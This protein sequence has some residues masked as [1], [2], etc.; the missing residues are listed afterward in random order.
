MS[1]IHQ[2]LT[3]YHGCDYVSAAGIAQHGVD[4]DASRVRNDF[5]RGFYVTT[6]EAQ[7][8]QWANN[9]YAFYELRASCAAVVSFLVAR[10]QL[11][12]LF[13]MAFVRGGGAE[14][15]YRALVEHCRTGGDHRHPG[16]TSAFY[17]VVYGP[18]SLYP[19]VG[20]KDDFDQI[21]FHTPEA[22]RVLGQ[23]TI[24]CAS[25]GPQFKRRG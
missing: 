7:A 20:V 2:P 25:P 16:R 1:W 12:E 15:D 5:G 14:S 4:L 9:K 3:V 19:R 17:D 11:A 18:V 8:K 23:P 21:S 22:I 6:N 13:T 10:E 24:E